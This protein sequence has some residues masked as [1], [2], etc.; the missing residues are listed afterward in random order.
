MSHQ[1]RHN[2]IT[3]FSV[4]CLFSIAVPA[5][6][7]PGAELVQAIQAE[8]AKDPDLGNIST[9]IEGA[10]VRLGGEVPSL[11]AQAQAIDI[12]RR[13]G[14]VNSVV[15]DMTIPAAESDQAIAEGVVEALQRYPHLTIWDHVD[16]VINNGVV[17][18]EGMVTPDR[19]KSQEIRLEVA[20]VPGVQQIQDSIQVTSPSAEDRRIRSRIARR[21]I[22]HGDPFERFASMRNPPIRILIDNGIVV[23]LGYLGNQGDTIELQRIVAQTQGVLRVDNQVVTRD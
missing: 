15:N 19:N 14:G 2:F 16:G 6:A 5:L 11:H 22:S 4:I 12:A 8:F 17:T 18:L 1:E 9:E 13:T 21:L 10:V 23:L 7:Q 3:Y 20:K